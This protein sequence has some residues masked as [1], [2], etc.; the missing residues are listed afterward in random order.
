MVI[1]QKAKVWI[2]CFIKE[3]CMKKF[4]FLLFVMFSSLFIM[5]S[6][7]W[8]QI[9]ID[10]SDPRFQVSGNGEWFTM[11]REY[12]LTDS[13]SEMYGDD[14]RYNVSGSGRDAAT[15]TFDISESG[16]Y[17]VY[18]WWP[19]DSRC[20]DNTPYTIDFNFE[21][22]TVQVNQQENAGQWNLLIRGFFDVGEH[23]IVISDAANPGIV[24]ADAVMIAREIVSNNSPVLDPIGNRSVNVG[25]ELQ[26]TVMGSDPDEDNLTYHVGDLPEGASFDP[27]SHIFS[28]TPGIEQVGSVTVFFTVTDHGEPPMTDSEGIEIVVQSSSFVDLIVDNSDP[29]FEV[30]GPGPWYLWTENVEPFYGDDVRYNLSG[31]GADLAV[32][33][34]EIPIAGNYEVYAWW[35]SGPQASSNTPY[36]IQFPLDPVTVRVNQQDDAVEGQWNLLA[37]GYFNLGIHQ[38]IVSDDADGQ[39]VVADAVRVVYLPL[40][41]HSPI[42]HDIGDKIVYDGGLL[43]FTVSA[44]DPDGDNLTY[45]VEGL[46]EG[47]SFDSESYLFSW[48]PGNDQYGSYSLIFTVTDDGDPIMST[49]EG[50]IITVESQPSIDIIIDNSDPG[51][52]VNGPGPWY[53]WAENV[54]PFYGDDVRY[55][56]SGIGADLAIYN[57]E[58]LVAGNYEVYAWWPSG[59]E[60]ASNT[61]YTIYFS[62]E[63]ITIMANQQDDVFEGQWNLLAIGFFDE[64]EHQIV[65]SDDANGQIV[66]ADAIRILPETISNEPPI[67]ES[68]GDKTV[69]EGD[70]L[71]F[72]V[73]GS[74]PDGDN[75]TYTVEGLPEGATFDSESHIF[76]WT[77]S[78]LHG[79]TF[80]VL[81][82]ITDDGEPSMTDSEEI[83][84]TVID[85]YISPVLEHIGDQIINEGELLQFT[86]EASNQGGNDLIFAA[87]NLPPDAT[88]NPETQLFSWSPT[89]LDSGKYSNIIFTVSDGVGSDNEIVSISVIDKSPLEAPTGLDVMDA[90]GAVVLTWDELDSEL[91]SGYNIYRS[92]MDPGNYEKLNDSP[93]TMNE[94]TDSSIESGNSYYYFVTA[95]DI[96]EQ[97]EDISNGLSYPV[98]VEYN[99][100]GELYASSITD[101]VVWQ[102]DI[103]GN[104]SIYTQGLGSSTS[105]VFR[106]DDLFVADYS[107]GRIWQILPDGTPVQYASSLILDEPSG[108][109]FN[110]AGE[111]FV[112]DDDTGMIHRIS[113]DG[114]SSE[115]FVEGLLGPAGIIFDD[116]WNLYVG[117]DKWDPPEGEDRTAVGTISYIDP[118]GSIT[119]LATVQDPDGMDFDLFGDIYVCQSFLNDSDNSEVTKIMSDRS[120][121]PVATLLR[122]P[123]GCC[124]NEFNELIVALP[125][126]G[127]ITK[128]HL[129]HESDISNKARI[130]PG[131]T[132]TAPVGLRVAL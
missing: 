24:V 106:G 96:Y 117:E 83:S 45:T 56:L 76:S 54:E 105:L 26:F 57:F 65:I 120:T 59:P 42:L 41:N 51:F 132:L 1:L 81:F 21:T 72:T 53:L 28:W 63:P 88:F 98:N 122:A 3:D 33:N 114:E 20:S 131:F 68:I 9:V 101:G 27:E 130:I 73:I 78:S 118:D 14:V 52:E 2:F 7:I 69:N 17:E 8:A 40:H 84:I 30:N 35:P 112:S 34:F 16:N 77:P 79:G 15:Y 103:E 100:A 94:F 64:G 109:A 127:V 10:N 102:I 87:T 37:E 80:P 6:S 32:Y 128:V 108:L 125:H 61:P 93:V 97:I 38:V 75:L 107:G 18:A 22:V 115:I 29:G 48:S 110:E 47:A 119:Y 25:E 46:P 85:V 62:D 71:Q 90:G 74:D 67:L 60:A 66:V 91:L 121:K 43:E 92:T 111:L 99:S 129:S 23:H 4:Y 55:N 5:T 13:V 31:L 70:L 11:V 116:S 123:W 39:I 12:D 113:A 126:A 89:W 95:V 86:V 124:M 49:S 36:T 19:S 104:A 50:I 44:T 58:I 82:T